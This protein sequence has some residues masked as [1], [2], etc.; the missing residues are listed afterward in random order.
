M[1]FPRS[2]PVFIPKDMLANWFE[3]YAEAM[4]LNAWTQTEIVGGWWGP[5]RR[6]A[7]NAPYGSPGI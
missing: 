5:S 2:W 4:E 7:E 6:S 1:P 3:I